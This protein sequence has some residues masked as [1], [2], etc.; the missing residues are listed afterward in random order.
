MM[1][2]FTER[3]MKMT[4]NNLITKQFLVTVSSGK[5][6]IAKAVIT[7]EQIKRALKDNTIVIISGTTNSYI[8]EELLMQLGVLGDFQKDTFFRG[9]TTAPGRKVEPKSEGYFGKDIIFEKGQWIKDKTIFDV[10]PNLVHGD[11]II[12]GAN[13]VAADR[14][15]A[16]IQIGNPTLG[17][18]GAIMQAVIGKRVELIIPVGLEKRVFSDIGLIAAKLNAP[19]STGL[20]LFPVSS[21]IITELEAI[22]QLTGASAELVAAGGVL[23]AEGSCWIAVTGTE[24]QLEITENLISGISKEP[25]FGES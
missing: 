16:G 5:R 24:E 20:R 17:T 2:Y 19:A 7:L 8:A 10:A 12:K 22:E 23:G 13:A 15:L 1:K 9:V 11:I 6:L 3:R 21:T 14:K 4:T 18:T 25:S